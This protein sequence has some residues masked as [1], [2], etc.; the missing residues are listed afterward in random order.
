MGRIMRIFIDKSNM[1]SLFTILHVNH[2]KFILFQYHYL[3]IS[4][5]VNTVTV[6]IVFV[7]Q[8]EGICLSNF[9]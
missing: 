7:S 6:C 1:A 4:T 9:C 3:V 2:I 8:Y 5:V